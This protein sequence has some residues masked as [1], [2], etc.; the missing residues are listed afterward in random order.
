MSFGQP[1]SDHF[2]REGEPYKRL[3]EEAGDPIV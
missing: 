1:F 2:L 3:L